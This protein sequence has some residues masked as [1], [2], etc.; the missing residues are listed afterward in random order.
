MTG[1]PTMLCLCVSIAL[2][3]GGS[4]RERWVGEDKLKHFAASFLVTSM[5]ASVVRAV[6]AAPAQSAWIGA[7]A[8]GGV[9]LW[10]EARDLRTGKGTPSLADLVWD[11]A[12]AGAAAALLSKAR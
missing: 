6:G 3:Q 2:S 12:G 7:A 8:G 1:L 4:S 11:G 5:A 9:G 10:K